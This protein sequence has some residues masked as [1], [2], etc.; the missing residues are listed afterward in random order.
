[1][2]KK[3]VNLWQYVIVNHRSNS[4]IVLYPHIISAFNKIIDIDVLIHRFIFG[5]VTH[6]PYKQNHWH[7]LQGLIAM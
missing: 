3:S 1:M 5:S 2:M 7:S 6:M 4:I